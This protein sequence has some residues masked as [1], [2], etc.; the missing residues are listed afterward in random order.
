MAH[1]GETAASGPASRTTA[2]RFV[3]GARPGRH[4]PAGVRAS[5][6]DFYEPLVRPLNRNGAGDT[7]LP[8]LATLPSSACDGSTQKSNPTTW[9]FELIDEAF[10]EQ[11]RKAIWEAPASACRL[12]RRSSTSRPTG[13]DTATDARTLSRLP[14]SAVRTAREIGPRNRKGLLGRLRWRLKGRVIWQRWI[15]AHSP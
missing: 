1:G 13:R 12:S 8:P 4:T 10:L 7:L 2:N 15:A 3:S 14:S 11:C 9:R 5:V 6:F